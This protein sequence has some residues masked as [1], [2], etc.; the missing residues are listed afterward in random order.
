MLHS[1]FLSCETE[2]AIL[3]A[4]GYV[5]SKKRSFCQI[6]ERYG[7]SRSFGTAALWVSARFR[8]RG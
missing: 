3:L 4:S 8:S 1:S 2:C 6:A 5:Y 7:R